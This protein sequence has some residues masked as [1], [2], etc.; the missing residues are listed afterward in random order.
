M[1]ARIENGNIRTYKSLPR[2]FKTEDGKV[3]L[4]FNRGSEELHRSYGFFDVVS[5]SYD[6]VVEKLGAIEWSEEDNSF[7]RFK[8]SKSISK[9]LSE[10]KSDKISMVKKKAGEELSGTDWYVTRKIE[11]GVDI[12]QEIADRRA[13]SRAKSEALESEINS[14][15]TKA[16]V[17]RWSYP[18]ENSLDI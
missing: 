7:R 13:E 15:T 9:T 11:T 3:I 1:K 17:L 10:L 12:P 14:L 5:D 8:V 6:S 16:K 4:N 18:V 2:T